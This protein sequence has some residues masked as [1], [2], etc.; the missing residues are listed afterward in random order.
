MGFFKIALGL[1]N[2]FRQLAGEVLLFANVI[3]DVVE[4]NRPSICVLSRLSTPPKRRLAC[5]LSH[6]PIKEAL[7]LIFLP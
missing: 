5:R 1:L 7:L 2:D 4:L 6:R 3:D